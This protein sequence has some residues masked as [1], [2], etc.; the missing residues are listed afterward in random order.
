VGEQQMRTT[1]EMRA[2]AR[3]RLNTQGDGAVLWSDLLALLDDLDEQIQRVKGAEI[4]AKSLKS[5]AERLMM[6]LASG[7]DGKWEDANDEW[8]E[9]IQAAHPSR[10]G[11]HE[12]YADAM[13]MV[14]NRHSK[15]GLI[16]LVNWLLLGQSDQHAKLVDV[17]D[18]L[19]GKVQRRDDAL[20]IAASISS[21]EPEQD[22]GS[23]PECKWC[24]ARETTD[25]EHFIHKTTC[26]YRIFH[27]KLLEIKTEDDD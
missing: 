7:D 20:K 8:S 16:A 25:G 24:F 17:A 22:C 12:Q 15:H 4:E 14:G 13:R 21:A 11:S 26:E 1:P 2:S 9:R 5:C 23:G 6:L 27:L 19:R 3:E 18:R 10:S